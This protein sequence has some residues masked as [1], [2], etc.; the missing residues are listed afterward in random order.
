[1]PRDPYKSREMLKRR[2][3]AG[4]GEK[5]PVIRE[6][7]KRKIFREGAKA[8][9]EYNR[10]DVAFIRTPT[11]RTKGERHAEEEA[12]RSPGSLEQRIARMNEAR[13]AFTGERM[14]RGA[15]IGKSSREPETPTRFISRLP[16]RSGRRSESRR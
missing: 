9:R 7:F 4:R 3:P 5:E 15:G 13:E 12:W 11:R 16:V 8:G 14:S 2:P 10:P 6:P 1:M